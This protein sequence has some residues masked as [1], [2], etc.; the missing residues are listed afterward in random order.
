MAAPHDKLSWHDPASGQGR[1]ELLAP[2]TQI[3][4]DRETYLGQGRHDVGRRVS[5][6]EVELFASTDAASALQLE[7]TQHKP[8][9]I[10][11]HDIGTSASLRLL[12]SLASA[13]RRGVQKLSVRRQGQGMAMVMLRFVELQ[14]GDGTPVRVYATDLGSDGPMRQPVAK[15]LLANS[16][17]GVLLMGGLSPTA[18]GNLLQPINGAVITGPWPNRELLMVPLG[19]GLPLASHA[20]QLAG[21]SAVAVHVTP[22][23]GKTRQAWAYIAGAWNRLHGSAASG[24][25]MPTEF[26]A[27]AMPS[28][29]PVSRSDAPTEIM[30]LRPLPDSP[31]ALG[32]SRPVSETGSWQAYIDRCAQLKGVLAGCVFDTR[33]MHPLAHSGPVA[34]A[35]Q[36]AEQG[37]GLLQAMSTATQAIGLSGTPSE[38]AITVGGHHL[39]LRPVAGHTGLAVHLL[40]SV[41]TNL[42]LARMQLERISPPA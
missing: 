16:Q 18:L 9:F 10:A 4:S 5:D 19:S 42:T 3:V 25:A 31:A 29:A 24:Q 30:D 34:M 20:T 38:G 27:P 13:A 40:L 1:D 6:D 33:A 26:G 21:H 35:A 2:L 12:A 11:V 37:A 28:P 39:L 41:S 36:L 32:A 7:F 22:H 23:A 8:H 15:V 14:L 17:L